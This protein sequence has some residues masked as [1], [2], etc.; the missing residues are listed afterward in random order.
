MKLLSLIIEQPNTSNT[1]S[2][3]GAGGMPVG[4]PDMLTKIIGVGFELLF[5]IAIILALLS[6]LWGGF[7]WITS[8]GEKQR[9]GRARER[10]VYSILGL[11]VVFL[12]MFIVNLIYWFFFKDTVN[13]FVFDPF[14]RT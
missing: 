9:I 5:T 12:S 11:I 13:P 6:L 7:N 14:N 4:G 3:N 8:E 1:V 10:I 2:L